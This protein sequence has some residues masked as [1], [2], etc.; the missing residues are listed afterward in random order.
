MYHITGKGEID[1]C[2][3][4]P[5]NCPL[6]DSPHGTREEIEAQL[7]EQ[8]GLMPTVTSRKLPPFEPMPEKWDEYEN[9]FWRA[10]EKK[11]GLLIHKGIP[12]VLGDSSK[13]VYYCLDCNTQFPKSDDFK[14]PGWKK[15]CENCL[16]LSEDGIV[17]YTLK[18]GAEKF[19][20]KEAV[21]E[22]EWY[23]YTSHA[24]WESF[25]NPGNPEATVIHLGTEEA[26]LDR[27]NHTRAS[28]DIKLYKVR[29]KQHA[30]VAD[31]IL[32]DD[33]YNDKIP[34]LVA[35]GGVQQGILMSGVTRY[36]NAYE[37]P[38]SFS[39]MVNPELIEIVDVTELNYEDRRR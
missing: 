2:R 6:E 28:R 36:Q 12:Y 19:F 1:L 8:Y 10:V 14:S 11:L 27:W 17:G 38:G 5:G 24:E 33:P 21:L 30:E 13:S 37:D 20:E 9:E 26:A 34:P 16:Q 29:L 25:L 3:A 35:D 22:S 7:E 39:L 31:N 18:P 32:Q 15:R 4:K 23:H